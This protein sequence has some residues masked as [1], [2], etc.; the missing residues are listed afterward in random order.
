[1]KQPRQYLA[2]GELS[3]YF[4]GIHAI[5]YENG[6]WKGAADPA[7]W[8]GKVCE[9]EVRSGW[10]EELYEETQKTITM[11]SDRLGFRFAEREKNL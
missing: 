6:E 11:L 1:M 8:G 5:A 7:G 4:G 10:C 3:A 9:G 2:S